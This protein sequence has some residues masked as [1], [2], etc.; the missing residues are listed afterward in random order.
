MWYAAPN[1]HLCIFK[2]FETLCEYD[3]LETTQR[4]LV[5]HVHRGHVLIDHFRNLFGTMA[6]YR[7]RWAAG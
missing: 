1:L 5:D 3:G 4:F 7:V 2:D 6:F